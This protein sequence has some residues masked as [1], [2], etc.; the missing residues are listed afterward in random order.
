[1]EGFQRAYHSLFSSTAQ[2]YIVVRQKIKVKITRKL[3]DNFGNGRRP[4]SVRQ[5]SEEN[6]NPSVIL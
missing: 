5:E 3:S 6:P 1:M 2:K 4:G